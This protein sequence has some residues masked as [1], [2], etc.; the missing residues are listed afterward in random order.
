VL[1]VSLEL[2]GN[3]PFLVF[4]DADL[5]A[6]VEGALI[7]KMRNLGESCV[8]ANRLYAHESVAEEFGARLAERMGALT[9]G[10]GTEEGVD[11]GPL[12][13]RQ[14]RERVAELVADA[15]SAGARTLVGGTRLDG[16]GWFYEPT[17]LDRVPRTASLLH[18]EIFGPVAPVVTFAT[19]DEVVAAANDS[20]FGLVA[21]AYTQDLRRALR[22]VERL[23]TGMV[24]LNR[25]VISNAAA[26]FGGIKHS[27]LGKEGGSEGIEEYLVHKYAG[28]DL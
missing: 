9:V 7:A 17:V 6:A 27:G 13:H 4:E 1:R 14:A 24:G 25:G 23:E 3:A 11:V 26:P 19:E 28:I 2:G 18:T 22:L 16:P 12:I 10:R 8:A 5:D 20:P 15:A 21:Y